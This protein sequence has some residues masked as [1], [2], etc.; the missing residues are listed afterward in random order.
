MGFSS[1]AFLQAK[2]PKVKPMHD[3][4]S[5]NSLLIHHLKI[6]TLVFASYAGAAVNG[7]LRIECRYVKPMCESK[8]V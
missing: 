8:A 6:H 4:N 2:V 7:F 5:I 1:A 3:R